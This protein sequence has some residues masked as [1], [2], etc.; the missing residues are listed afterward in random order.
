M[1]AA[2]LEKWGA[3]LTLV[4]IQVND[5]SPDE[6]LVRTVA[7][8][9]CH[10]D[11][12]MQNGAWSSLPLPMIPGHEAS[13]VVEMVGSGVS[14]VKVGDH[15]VISAAAF[16]GE[17]EWCMRGLLQHCTTKRRTRPADQPSRLTWNGKPAE[18]YVGL[19][20]FAEYMLVHERAVVQIPNE[21]PLDKAALLGCAVVTGIGVV[22]YKAE[23]S[24][25][26]TVAVLGCGGVGLNVVQAARMVGAGRIIAIDVLTSKLDQAKAFGA[27]DIVDAS[28]V[29]PV[30]AVRE[31]TGG[32]VDH[33]IEVIGRSRTIEQAFAMLRTC[34]TTTVVG[35]TTPGDPVTIPADALLDEKRLQGSRSGSGKFRLDIP[36]YCQWYLDGRLKL[37]EL[38]AEHIPLT[39][40]NAALEELDRSENLRS[41]ITFD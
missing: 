27:T 33:S 31:L 32:G 37:D 28:A 19:G 40:V 26:Q 7:S 17:C 24:A 39:G 8:G 4:D 20:G 38:V 22:R 34:G 11:R 5:V 36:L 29:D 25:G 1:K 3:P 21:M 13:G 30:E 23:V 12:T 35:V 41:I 15:V 9:V 2:I 6:V 16:C 18:S 10:S 14:S